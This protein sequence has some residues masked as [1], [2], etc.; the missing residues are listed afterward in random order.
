MQT[1]NIKKIKDKYIDGDYRICEIL[2]LYFTGNISEAYNVLNKRVYNLML[3]CISVSD[4][5]YTFYA[6]Q[7]N[8]KIKD[9]IEKHKSVY[10]L[11]GKDMP[12]NLANFN[13]EKYL[14]IKKLLV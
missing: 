13:M 3:K 7:I 12:E 8:A 1:V 5:Q 9:I 2:T 11:L 10:K 14:E 4:I 6:Q